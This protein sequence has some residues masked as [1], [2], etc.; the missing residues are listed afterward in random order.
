MRTG[1]SRSRLTGPYRGTRGL[2]PHSGLDYQEPRRVEIGGVFRFKESLVSDETDVEKMER[3]LRVERDVLR[4]NGDHL[5][6]NAINTYLQQADTDSKQ[7][8][9]DI[10]TAVR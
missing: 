9:Y 4:M 7:R 1:S 5:A 2:D 8:F 3:A 10:L 6:A